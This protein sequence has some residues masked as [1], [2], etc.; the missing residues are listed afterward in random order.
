MKLLLAGLAGIFVVI[1]FIPSGR[2]ENNPV[3]GKDIGS[4]SDIPEDVQGLLKNAC[5]DCHSQTTRFP[6]YSYV[7]P[8]S[9]LIAKDINRGRQH[10]DFSYWTDLSLKD[11]IKM[12]DDISE[13]VGEKE[14][15]M[16]IYVLMHPPSKLTE[17]QRDLIVQWAETSAGQLME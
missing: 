13:E 16:K 9:W 17:E 1:Q 2:P 11:R 7:A 4:H 10:L 8:V 3:T 5:F 15:P 14:M 12:L 6:W